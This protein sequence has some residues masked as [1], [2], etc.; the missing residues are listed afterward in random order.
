MTALFLVVLGGPFALGAARARMGENH[1]GE[2]I[3]EVVK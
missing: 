2:T 3:L 1:A